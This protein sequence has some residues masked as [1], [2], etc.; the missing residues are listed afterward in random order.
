M[1]TPTSAPSY[2]DSWYYRPA[3]I[4]GVLGPVT[5]AAVAALPDGA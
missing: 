1:S 2:Q 5:I 4:D 3:V